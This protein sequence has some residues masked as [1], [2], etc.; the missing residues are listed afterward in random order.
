ME[1][2]TY[3]GQKWSTVLFEQRM[4]LKLRG[5][6]RKYANFNTMR[7]NETNSAHKLLL[8]K[9]QRDIVE[10]VRERNSMNE[11]QDLLVKISGYNLK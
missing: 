11:F 6:A 10:I 5:L 4:K 2:E 7:K 3:G 9:C 1:R 8:R